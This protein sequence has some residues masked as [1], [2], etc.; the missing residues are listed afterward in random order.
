[1]V[2]PVVVGI[3]LL[4]TITLVMQPRLKKLSG[5]CAAKNITINTRYSLRHYRG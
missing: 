3:L 2:I 5:K 1:M 4:I